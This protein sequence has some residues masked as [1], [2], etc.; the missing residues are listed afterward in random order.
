MDTA[1]AFAAAAL[2]D[3]CQKSLVCM[4]QYV[5]AMVHLHKFFFYK[6]AFLSV[7]LCVYCLCVCICS[8]V[9]VCVFV[10]MCAR[11]CVFVSSRIL[12]S[13]GLTY[14]LPCVSVMMA[15]DPLLTLESGAGGGGA[16]GAYVS[17]LVAAVV[18]AAALDGGGG[19]SAA[20]KRD[21]GGGGEAAGD[22]EDDDP[23]DGDRNTEDS[24]DRPPTAGG[25]S[26]RT[27]GPRGVG[28]GVR[29]TVLVLREVDGEVGR[30]GDRLYG[31]GSG[32]RGP[33]GDRPVGAGLNDAG[34]GFGDGAIGLINLQ[35]KSSLSNTKWLFLC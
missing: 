6:N 13:S 11:A 17:G 19:G 25:D 3:T 2:C 28:D 9:C 24:G 7:F 8:C 33:H 23:G 21:G 4:K 14:I 10:C 5:T 20:E 15:R 31:E 12:V 18:A 35:L 1:S 30:S 26:D 34:C 16:E 29:G 22:D 32:E 27:A